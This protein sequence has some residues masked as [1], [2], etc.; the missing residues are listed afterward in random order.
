MNCCKKTTIREVSII[1]NHREMSLTEKN[2]KRV[3]KI[4]IIIK[5]R[6]TKV[7]PF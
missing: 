4:N 2:V 6:P 1:L 3:S 5:S 7:S